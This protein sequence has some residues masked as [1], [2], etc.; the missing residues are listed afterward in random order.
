MYY[1]SKTPAKP[2]YLNLLVKLPD[3][4]LLTELFFQLTTSSF[5][6]ILVM[7]MTKRFTG[8]LNMTQNSDNATQNNPASQTTSAGR[9]RIST[10]AMVLTALITAITCIL[11]PL[12]IPL[13]FSPVPISLTNLVIGF[14][15]Y[16]LGWKK[17][18]ASYIIYFLLGL[19]GLPVFSGFSGGFAKFAGPT[20]GYL[21]GF[22]FL[23][24]IGGLAVERFP[25]KRIIH[26]AGLVVGT[27]VTY[28]FGTFWLAFQMELSFAAALAIGVIPYLAGDAVK[29]IL[30]VIFGPELKKRVN[31][32]TA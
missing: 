28:I 21:V 23:T 10:S 14:S 17:A 32:G 7:K 24:I 4:S 6:L 18:T 26:I 13:P 30:A 12:S 3:K 15:V 8:G 31:A 25:Q 19:A 22:V 29:I 5:S 20:G 27:A 16:L 9:P 1:F 2:L 11:A